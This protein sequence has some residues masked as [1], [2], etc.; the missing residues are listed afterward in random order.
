MDDQP[1]QLSLQELLKISFEDG[2]KPQPSLATN[3]WNPL[4]AP[5]GNRANITANDISIK[6]VGAI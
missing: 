3:T 1:K 4:L 2:A 6:H 5:V